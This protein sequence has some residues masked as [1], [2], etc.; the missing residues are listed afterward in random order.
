MKLAASNIAW[1]PSEDDAA[2]RVLRRHGF[3]GIEIA[4]SKRWA[5][6]FDAT[7]TDIEAYRD[8]WGRRGFSIVSMQSLLFG[9]PDLQLFGSSAGRASLRDYVTG[10]IDIAGGLGARALVFGSPKN[11]KRGAM[12]LDEATAIAIDFFREMGTAAV[13]RDCVI[14]LEP[15][16]P[17]YDCDFITTTA[18]AVSLCRQIAHHGVAVN[19][20]AGT[21]ALNGEDPMTTIE[22]AASWFGHFHASEPSLV[23]LSDGPIQRACATALTSE[24]YDHWVSIE[25]RASGTSAIDALSRA[26]GVL[27]RLYGAPSPSS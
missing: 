18:E 27:G 4:P 17:V 24:R 7:S 11:R 21:I 16:P 19:G 12:P 2:A 13:A 1:D 6:P 10:L 25:M 26:A 23:E 14:C 22:S 9:R 8:A 5:S 15:N 3:S 20:D